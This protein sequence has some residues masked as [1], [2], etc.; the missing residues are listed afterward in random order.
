MSKTH[1]VKSMRWKGDPQ[2]CSLLLG[3]LRGML[4]TR[5]VTAG[6]TLLRALVPL[7]ILI[8]IFSLSTFLIFFLS[9]FL[10]FSLPIP[11]LH[12]LRNHTG[13]HE[14]H[15]ARGVLHGH[16]HPP[17]AIVLEVSIQLARR[18]SVR[19]GLFVVVRGKGLGTRWLLLLLRLAITARTRWLLLLLRLAITA[20][21]HQRLL[22]VG[23]PHLRVSH[24]KF[25]EL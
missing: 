22:T 6:T 25:S 17:P 1:T 4:S 20:R 5:L 8:L 3:F 23:A 9:T 12:H 19:E 14:S 2:G 16:S 11:L 24:G 21:Q 18:V 15:G 7:T 13:Q 10:I